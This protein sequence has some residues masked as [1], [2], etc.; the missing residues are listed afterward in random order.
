MNVLRQQ[1][2]LPQWRR[3]EGDVP[4]GGSLHRPL[5]WYF[6]SYQIPL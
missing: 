6:I 3:S 2:E 5:L 1:C 4:S